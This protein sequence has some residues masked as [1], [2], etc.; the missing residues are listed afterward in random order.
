VCSFRKQSDSSKYRNEANLKETQRATGLGRHV[1]TTSKVD[2]RAS[3]LG[4]TSDIL[5]DGTAIVAETKAAI[6]DAV[7]ARAS[8]RDL[9]GWAGA[10]RGIAVSSGAGS[11]SISAARGSGLSDNGQTGGRRGASGGTGCA[12]VESTAGTDASGRRQSGGDING[13]SRRCSRGSGAGISGGSAAAAGI[14]AT[15]V[16]T[17]GASTN[18]S[19]SRWLHDGVDRGTISAVLVGNILARVGEL[20]GLILNGST[21]V[22][23]FNI[24]NEHGGKFFNLVLT[25]GKGDGST[26]HVH[27]TVS[28]AVEP[29]PGENSITVLDLRGNSEVEV[30]DTVITTAG[31]TFNG[32]DQV[33][34]GV[35]RA[36]VNERV[37]DLP[38]GGVLQSGSIGLIG[39]RNLARATTVDGSVGT[40]T[41]FELERL[42][43][44][45]SH[46]SPGAGVATDIDTVAREVGSA[47]VEGVLG[48]GTRNGSRLRD[49][50][51]THGGADDSQNSS[52]V[53]GI[54]NHF[55]QETRPACEDDQSV[56]WEG[57]RLKN[58]DSRRSRHGKQR[59]R[60]KSNQ[61]Q[62]D[63]MMRNAK[64]RK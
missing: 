25:A 2:F 34:G 22:D 28:N 31:G 10:G 29:S 42:A 59:R 32:S 38:V 37:D 35:G 13:S 20:G 50:K 52:E 56:I 8:A 18:T 57:V 15:A 23:A 40:T 4:A 16:A 48:S 33:T 58:L 3:A 9:A 60:K 12:L 30:I 47:G 39:D 43:R 11:S 24:G 7:E 53:G 61:S 41:K 1:G 51:M 55:E 14:T 64:R 62:A 6:G 19:T 27:L 21:R 17:T 45:N 26:I 63:W 54:G 44:A 46:A 49:E 36:A 5:R